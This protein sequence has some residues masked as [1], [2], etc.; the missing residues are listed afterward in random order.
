MHSRR[1]FA[2]TL[3]VVLA[4][5]APAAPPARAQEP[6]RPVP[7]LAGGGSVTLPYAELRALWL[8]A[9]A[10]KPPPVPPPPVPPVAF[11][12][13]AARVA[14][15]VAA[16]GHSVRGRA[17]FEVQT[18]L[19]GWTTVPLLPA[20]GTRLTGV[21]PTGALVAV[22][23]DAL[24]LLLNK[25]DRQ[26]VTLLFTAPLAED[27][28]LTLVPG[29]AAPVNELTVGNVPPGTLAEVAGATRDE[30]TGA[31][32]LAAGQPLAL[33]LVR[34]EDRRPAPPPAPSVWRVA[35]EVLV[36]YDDG[37][38]VY[39]TR[40]RAA[41][42][43]GSGRALELALPNAAEVLRVDGADLDRWRTEKTPDGH[44]RL[45]VAWKTPDLLRR[46]LFVDYDLALSAPEEDWPLVAP[47][48]VPPEGSAA[49]STP[50]EGPITA[51]ATASFTLALPDGL[52]FPGAEPGDLRTAPRWVV[53]ALENRPFVTVTANAPKPDTVLAV[54]RARRLPLVPTAPATV[55]EAGFK[56][57]LVADGATLTEA[58]FA[59]RHDGPLPFTVALPDGAT[60]LACA[61][62]DRETAPVDRGDHRLEFPLPAGAGK[63]TITR[64]TFSYSGRT[65]AP[66]APVA[67]QVSLALPQTGL[68][69][70]TLR[71][72]LQIPDAYELTALDGNVELT[73]APKDA[74]ATDAAIHLRKELLKGERPAAE[75]FYQKKAVTP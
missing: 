70:E 46:E 30:A 72:D 74:P 41:A 7:E 58:R 68:F 24:A 5:A 1:P 43:D 13:G 66:L 23:D 3:T 44:R 53:A 60:L 14:L 35:A 8:A 62:D 33:T 54:A 10:P 65:A 20:T 21:E 26:T 75:L 56:T 28:K 50:T 16:D 51:A 18:F 59:V 42:D 27:G 2:A 11:N 32:H 6:P 25:P 38:L 17:T 31:F 19:E 22:R 71:W 48:A 69:T 9:Q 52:E 49:A 64:V 40:L 73:P 29:T 12:V 67:G 57:R 45:L 63:G 4:T 47:Q 15:E 55:E 36:R 34:T 61:V 39:R 37:R